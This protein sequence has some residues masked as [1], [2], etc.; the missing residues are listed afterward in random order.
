MLR[1]ISVF[2]CYLVSLGRSKKL[3]EK[4]SA[5]AQGEGIHVHPE[6]GG[7]SLQLLCPAHLVSLRSKDSQVRQSQRWQLF[8]I[9]LL[10]L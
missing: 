7:T 4:V 3:L 10:E 8:I 2:F 9:K 5:I 1:L 6:H